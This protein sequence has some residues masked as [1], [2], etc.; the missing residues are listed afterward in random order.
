MDSSGEPVQH[1]GSSGGYLLVDRLLTRSPDPS[2]P[3]IAAFL[4]L[5]IGDARV[6]RFGS[7]AGAGLV[8]LGL[9]PGPQNEVG[10][11]V[12]SARNGSRYMEQQD[13]LGTPPQR[14]QTALSLTY[15]AQISKSLA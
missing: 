3:R 14:S 11:A 8:A 5:G 4:Q 2:G 9:F 13:Q 12:P 1:R 6:N 7:Y 10:I 15:L